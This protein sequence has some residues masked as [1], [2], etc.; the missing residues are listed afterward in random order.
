MSEAMMDLAGKYKTLERRLKALERLEAAAGDVAAWGRAVGMLQLF[1]GVRGIWPM[2]V[3]D[4]SGSA[5]DI[6][7]SGNNLTQVAVPLFGSSSIGLIPFTIYN[8]TNQYHYHADSAEFDIT[9]IDTYTWS[10]IRGLTLGCWVNFDD[11]APATNEGIMTKRS[12]ADIGYYLVRQTS[13]ILL[14]GGSTSSVTG[15]AVTNGVWYF[16][17]C[18]FT[19]STEMFMY[20]NGVS[21]SNISSIQASLLNSTEPFMVGARSDGGGGASLFLDGR[22]SLA[23][24]CAAAVPDLFIERF[25]QYSRGLFGV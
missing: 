2:S 22:V 8:G 23:F 17:A 21:Y 1:P 13:N 25:Y 20:V 16:I 19:P 6:S 7:G 24:L 3:A 4:S 5:I 12:G 18:R 11:A 9:G 15:A 10:V 14:F